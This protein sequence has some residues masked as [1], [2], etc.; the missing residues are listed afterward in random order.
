MKV[1]IKKLHSIKS[2]AEKYKVTTSG[3]DKWYKKPDKS[4]VCTDST[5]LIKFRALNIGGT[6][7]ILEL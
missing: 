6:K 3:V 2:F 1:D 7:I 4:G 5:G